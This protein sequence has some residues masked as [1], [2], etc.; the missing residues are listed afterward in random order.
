MKIKERIK[1]IR[2]NPLHK[3]IFAVCFSLIATTAFAIYNAYLG[4][5]FGDYF[6]TGIAIYYLLLISVRVCSI[7]VEKK[8]ALKEEHIKSSIRIKLYK[9]LSCFV[10]IIDLCLIAP[11]ILM[12]VAPKDVN[13]GIIPAITMATYTCYKIIVAIVNY[14]KSKRTINPTIILLREINIIDAMVSILTLQHTLIMV[15]GGM[16]ESMETLSLIS[17]IGF[18]FIIVLFSVISFINN[19]KFLKEKLQ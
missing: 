12:V 8:I 3:T 11:I 7:I 6:A 17:S 15:N 4:L 9:I 13:F 2:E 10:F 18:I 5:F 19:K 1:A 14:K 16:N